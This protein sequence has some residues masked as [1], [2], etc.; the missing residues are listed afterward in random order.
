MKSSSHLPESAV[1]LWRLLSEDE[2][3]Y[4]EAAQAL[5]CSHRHV[6]RL[7][8][9]LQRHGV[10]VTTTTRGGCTFFSVEKA[11]ERIVSSEPLTSHELIA[12]RMAVDAARTVLAATPLASDAESAFAKLM[13]RLNGAVDQG[14]PQW[15]H[16]YGLE[17]R[18]A[19]SDAFAVILK[20]I[21]NQMVVT[22]R[23]TKPNATT[24]GRTVNP[25][26]IVIKERSAAL[27]AWCHLRDDYRYFTLARI[28]GAQIDP[29][30]RR[31]ERPSDFDPQTFF[32]PDVGGAFT[33]G[34]PERFSLMVEENVAHLFDEKE[35]YR[36][37]QIDE[38]RPDGS[39][40]VVSYESSGFDE[41][42]S[43]V[44]S[45]GTSVTALEPPELRAA[46]ASDAAE[47]AHRYA[48]GG[49]A[50]SDLRGSE[51]HVEVS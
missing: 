31:F 19:D 13:P 40:L 2:H 37:Q 34:A 5:G 25:L 39:P 43:F 20:G 27:L 26:C 8:R 15:W 35:Y 32:R 10:S 1:V 21:S 47:L 33:E 28:A 22:L 6:L 45:W 46:L 16:I 9:K 41:M 7:V 51:Q 24:E 36:L 17:Q 49:C 18:K 44:Q 38:R 23:Y 14:R 30:S 50:G 11:P 42:R 3:T 4:A 29:D 12:L 48:P